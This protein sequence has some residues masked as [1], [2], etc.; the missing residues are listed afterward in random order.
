M[1]RISLL[2]ALAALLALS[3]PALAAAPAWQFDPPHCQIIFQIKHVFAPVMGQFMKFG[4]KVNF[5]P[6]DLATSK[7]E[8]TIDAASLDTGVDARDNHLRTADFFD[9]KRYPHITFRSTSFQAKGKNRFV[10][11]GKLTMKD[12]TKPVEL[13]FNYLGSKPNPMNKG[14][15]VAG[16]TS[17]FYLDRLDY[18]VG[19][20]KFY[21]QGVVGN[22][23]LVYIHLE[24][25]R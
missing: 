24:L 16:F 14:Q 6:D 10:V 17:E 18:H 19:S 8:L 2:V 3:A 11:K 22:K 25:V 13:V 20:G 15:M 1:R 21:E 4:G 12:V 9:T 5:S 7:V 23:V